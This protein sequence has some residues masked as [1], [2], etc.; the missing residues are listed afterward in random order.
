MP[1]I[2]VKKHNEVFLRVFCED[3]IA[4]ELSEYFTFNVP[5]ARFQPAFKARLWDGR[6]KLF[7]LQ[8]KTLYVGLLSLL[9]NFAKRSNYTLEIDDLLTKNDQISKEMIENFLPLIKPHSN[10]KPLE[11]RDYQLDAIVKA[12]QTERVLLLSP[13]GC[14]DADTIIS[15]EIL[16]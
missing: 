5:G 16:D 12:I 15:A 1:D 9:E 6:K 7:N 3:H 14:L 2:T 11:I 10:G 13:T 8:T 4:K